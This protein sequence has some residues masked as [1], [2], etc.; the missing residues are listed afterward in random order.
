MPCP[1]AALLLLRME[2]WARGTRGG[3]T[4]GAAPCRAVLGAARVWALSLHPRQ[5]QN[6]R[7]AQ[8]LSSAIDRGH[9]SLAAEL[10]GRSIVVFLPSLHPAKGSRWFCHSYY[11]EKPSRCCP[12]G[13]PALPSSIPDH[14]LQNCALE[15][16]SRALGGW[17][18][19]HGCGDSDV[20][21]T[22]VP[23][24]GRG[25]F[26]QQAAGLWGSCSHS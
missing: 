16:G 13:A 14:Q 6:P 8:H 9:A 2:M 4:V 20:G 23:G 24:R 19:S 18:L 7:R 22:P 17:W 11:Q 15:P 12:W 26:P 1:S 10:A 21:P 5:M 3:C 25:S